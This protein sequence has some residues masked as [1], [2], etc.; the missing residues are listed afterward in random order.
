MDDAFDPLSLKHLFLSR[1]FTDAVTL[2]ELVV[3]FVVGFI[4]LLHS[5]M[6]MLQAIFELTNVD[7]SLGCID[8]FTEAIPN[9]CY[10]FAGVSVLAVHALV[11]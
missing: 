10:P 11:R 5:A 1:N 3:S 4:A 6:A 9:T 2:A 7:S 8:I